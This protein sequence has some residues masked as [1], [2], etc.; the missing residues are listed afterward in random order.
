[1]GQDKPADVAAIVAYL[2]S[3]ESGFVTG[4]VIDVIGGSYFT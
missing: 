4:A 2:A 3:P 1:M